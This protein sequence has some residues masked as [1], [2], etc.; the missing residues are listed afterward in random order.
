[1]VLRY[2]GEKM[3][4]IDLNQGEIDKQPR[5]RSWPRGRHPFQ[6]PMILSALAAATSE[7]SRV[8]LQRPC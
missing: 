8:V 4:N 3:L 2:G 1:M 7:S 5:P 6:C